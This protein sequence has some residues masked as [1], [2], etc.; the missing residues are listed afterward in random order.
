MKHIIPSRFYISS[1]TPQCTSSAQEAAAPFPFIYES[2]CYV[3]FLGYNS[4]LLGLPYLLVT[5]VGHIYLFPP[6]PRE[7]GLTL[8]KVLFLQMHRTVCDPLTRGSQQIPC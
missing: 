5:R 1:K 3:V 4:L 2:G 8:A 6:F 7:Q